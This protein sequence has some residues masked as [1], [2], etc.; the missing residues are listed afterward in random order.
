MRILIIG[1]GATGRTLAATLREMNHDIV[2][3]D[4]DPD[5]LAAADAL[6]DVMTHIGEGASPVALE[7]AGIGKAD[8][9]L[10]VTNRDETNLLACLYAHAAGVATKVARVSNTDH[11]SPSRWNWKAQ[12]LDLLVSQN[13]ECAKE[14]LD[15]LRYPGAADVLDMFE[16][17]ILAVG[18]RIA[19]GSPLADRTLVEAGQSHEI[20]SRSR[21]VALL[22]DDR[23]L[24]PRGDTRLLAGDN[25]YVVLQAADVDTFLDWALRD[26]P[27][28]RRHIV[29]GGGGI[30]LTLAL[31]ME[32]QGMDVVLIEHDGARAELAAEKLRR[33]LV[34]HGDA[35]KKETLREAGIGPG[36]A[37]TALTGDDELNIVSCVLAKTSGADWTVT[38]SGKPEYVPIIR[39]MKLLDRVIS[40]YTTMI[41]VILRFVRGRNVRAATLF[42]SLP[43]ELLEVDVG[44]ESKWRR[45]SL[46]QVPL[47]GGAIV[48]LVQRKGEVHIPAGDF[49]L[50]AGDRLAVFSELNNASRVA[51]VLKK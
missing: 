25:A 15:I 47:P 2:L 21:I 32:E 38:Q 27:R 46:R 35:A 20:L 39:H 30:G 51:A 49:E 31:K 6:V 24:I 1:A 40:P 50:Q 41:N 3:L 19:A 43:G 13:E 8:M 17:K 45:S 28:I 36:T 44:S 11:L 16:R 37:F 26:R 9:A 4:R 34:L 42:H 10:A 5:A 48:A 23:L 18:V 7:E 12:G 29:A 14:L 33:G 22:R